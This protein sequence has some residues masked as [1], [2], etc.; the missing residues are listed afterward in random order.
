MQALEG[1]W[2]DLAGLKTLD[3]SGAQLSEPAPL[4]ILRNLPKLRSLNVSGNPFMEDGSLSPEDARIEV[5][6]SHWRLATLNGLVVSSDEVETARLRNVERLRKAAEEAK[7]KE[8]AEAAE[9]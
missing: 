5:L 9:S 4:E 1:P 7:E 8:A 3:I 2:Q 6:I